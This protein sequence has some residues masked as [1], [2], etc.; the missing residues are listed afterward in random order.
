MARCKVS[1][2]LTHLVMVVSQ[3]LT[4]PTKFGLSYTI[5]ARIIYK[6]QTLINHCWIKKYIIQF[7]IL[8]YQHV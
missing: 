3:N 6:P 7:H 4:L 1:Q 5:D 2:D 8:Q